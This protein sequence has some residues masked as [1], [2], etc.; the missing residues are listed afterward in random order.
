MKK[1]FFII[2]LATIST[3]IGM[4]GNFTLFNP[5]TPI[6][7]EK[8]SDVK[9][10]VY[11]AL[12]MWA[13]DMQAVSGALPTD[14]QGLK[15]KARIHFLTLGQASS[16]LLKKIAAPVQDLKQYKESFYIKVHQDGLWVI[17]GDDQGLAY[18][19]LELSRLSGVSPWVWWQDMTPEPKASIEL[20]EHYSSFQHPSVAFRGVF[21]ND[22]D[23]S[24]QPWSWMHFDPQDKKGL[25]SAL[26][27]KKVFQLLLRLR[28]NTIWPGMHGI[29][30]PFYFIPGAKEMADSCGITVGTSHCEPLMCNANGEWEEA[31]RGRYNYITN[32]DAVISF[33]TDRLKSVHNYGNIYTMGMR[34]KH[35]GSMEGVKTLKEKTTALQRVIY[36]QRELLKKYV[37]KDLTQIP[38]QFVPYKEVLQIYENGLDVPEDIT[39]TWSDDNY[40]YMTRLS[41][42]EEQKRAGGSGIYY[43]LS[44]WGRPHDYMWLT[45]TQPGLIYSELSNAY[46]HNNKKMWIVNVHDPKVAGYDLELFLD[47]A[48][49]IDLKADKGQLSSHLKNYLTRE[50]GS[51]ATEILYPAFRQYYYLTAVR[52]PEFM[53][54]TQVELDKNRYPRGWSN[55]EG[56]DFSFTAF[57]D[58]ADRYLE[59]Y[60]HLEEQVQKAGVLIPQNRKDAYFATVQYPLLGA[61]AMATK[62]L[63][64][65]RARSL[66]TGNYDASFRSAHETALKTAAAKST[67]AYFKIKALTQYYN[68][69]LAGGKW[70]YAMSDQPRDLYVFD[71]P[72][73]PVGIKE[74]ELAQYENLDSQAADYPIQG[75]DSYISR[76]AIAFDK[77]SYQATAVDMLGHSMAAVPLPKQQ[78]LQY[79]FTTKKEGAAILYTAVIPTH[80]NDNGDIRYQVQIDNQPAQIISFR[81]KDRTEKW[82]L[83]VLRGQ[84]VD[85]T[86]IQLS[87]GEHTL[88]IT[89]LDDHVIFDQWMIDFNLDQKFYLFPVAPQL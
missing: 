68:D 71:M 4:A 59:A 42:P 39:L 46:A 1:R 57:G 48:W 62:W 43:H 79:H 61:A 49:D 64:A 88:K 53:A 35:D 31:R 89:A 6:R 72:Q 81:Q 21:I 76:N 20:P 16:S 9:P 73:L 67:Q 78:S 34:G 14:V 45:T 86:K 27:Y 7:Y 17:G 83:N 54:W 84:A 60:K 74:K 36:D 80:P 13:T 77:A 28:A 47:L 65:D 15:A 30:V 25:I 50:F 55:F 18:G 52:K 85:K 41:T 75:S 33:W 26:S 51:A 23:W 8:P 24:Y 29:T 3:K 19:I 38:Q 56:T 82:K 32:K 12:Q 63:E 44:Y 10:V 69:S 37:N 58:E 87:Q 11:T 40:G 66:A 2:L 5:S 22:E 70:K